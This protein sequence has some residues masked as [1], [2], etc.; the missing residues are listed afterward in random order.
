MNDLVRDKM[1]H[2]NG[3]IP[4]Y[5]EILAGGTVSQMTISVKL[6]APPCFGI[7]LKILIFLINRLALFSA[8]CRAG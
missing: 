4:L 6:I 3:T 7:Q 8:S 1:R 5:G 2:E